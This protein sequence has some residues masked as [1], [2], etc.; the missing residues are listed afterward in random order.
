MTDVSNNKPTR[1]NI[2]VSEHEKDVITRA[3]Q[4]VNATVS[5]FVLEKAY[6]EAEAILADQSQFRLDERQWKRFCQALDAPPKT[7]PALNK[8][9]SE[10]GVFDA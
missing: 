4:S 6:A 5:R 1:L 9:L 2:R 7:I 10:P 8:L 3:A